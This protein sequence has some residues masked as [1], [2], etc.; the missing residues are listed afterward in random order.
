MAN[1][2]PTPVPPPVPTPAEPEPPE[3]KAWA[4]HYDGP[5]QPV[6][7]RS[8]EMCNAASTKKCVKDSVRHGATPHACTT[9]FSAKI[10]MCHHHYGIGQ[11]LLEH[12]AAMGHVIHDEHQASWEA[13]KR[14]ILERAAGLAQLNVARIWVRAHANQDQPDMPFS[15]VHIEVIAHK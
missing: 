11:A 10:G 7:D 9:C 5:I 8:C 6:D 2:S 1:K 15:A 12:T 3:P 13:A 4:F 14:F